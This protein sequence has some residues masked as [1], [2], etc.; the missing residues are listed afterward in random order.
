MP[1]RPAYTRDDVDAFIDRARTSR[2]RP[3]I[4]RDLPP[5][6]AADGTCEP[7]LPVAL[8]DDREEG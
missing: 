3:P 7:P 1:R 5:L 6:V 8:P 4:P 2:P